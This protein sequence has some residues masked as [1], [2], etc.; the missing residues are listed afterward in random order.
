[1]YN[2]ASQVI[3]ARDGDRTVLTMAS[4][5]RG[6]VQDFA[7]V[8]PVPV[9]LKEDQV[10]VGNPKIVERLDRFSAPRLVEYFDS[11]PC[12]PPRPVPLF[13]PNAAM[14]ESATADSAGASARGV[15]IEAQFTVGEYDI[16]LLSATESAGLEAWL[17]ENDYN[18]PAGASELLQPYI[19]QGLKF[20]VAKVNLAEFAQSEYSSL[21]PL[22]MAFESP[23]FM[24]P[25]RLGTVNAEGEQ[26]LIVYLLSPQG[27][28]ELT[29]YRT[30]K[31]PSDVEIP[32]FVQQKFGEFYKSMFA[33]AH[34]REDKRV[35]FLEYAWN[36]ASCDPCSAPPLSP[37]ELRDA[38]VFWLD[39][40]GDFTPFRP[41]GS[42][43]VFV[44]RLHVR[45]TRDRFPEDLQFQLT[46][47]QQFFQGRYVIRHPFRGEMRCRAA[48]EY[49]QQVRD[50]QEREMQTLAQLTGWDLAE[51]R[52][53][54]DLIEAENP[55]PWWR[56]LWN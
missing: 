31:V 10:R 28:V 37:E 42:P 43:N 48:D 6:D 35:A 27:Q 23:R 5:F 53:Q 32:E 22:M 46:P 55:V 39:A 54:T 2:Q 51:I 24:L 36:I 12:A 30:V 56:R 1:L 13:S 9:L 19:R 21:R 25:I 20:F 11:D 15:T 38:G 41:S 16:L 8:V 3:I 18:I 50:R 44:T 17:R 26:D 14:Q 45:Y 7:L 29:N 4:D 40:G 49:R 33:T 52:D 47:N 34:A